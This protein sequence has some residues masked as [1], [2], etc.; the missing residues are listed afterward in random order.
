MDYA[1]LQY[2]GLASYGAMAGLA[3][4][5]WIGSFYTPEE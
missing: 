3:L 4:V 1:V 2:A 5:T